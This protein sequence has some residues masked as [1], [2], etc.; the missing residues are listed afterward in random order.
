[1]RPGSPLPLCFVLLTLGVGCSSP[2]PP[3]TPAR[4]RPIVVLETDFGSRED[5]PALLRGVVLAI[6]R[7]ATVVDLTHDVP[8]FDI[9]TGA[10]DLEDAP[11]VFPAGSVFVVVIDPGVGTGRKGIAV[12]LANGRFLVGPDNGVL[13]LAMERWGVKS[14]REI[15]NPAFQRQHQSETFHGRDVFSPA[16][17]FLAIGSPPFA[18]IGPEQ[19]DWVKLPTN[20]V[21]RASGSLHA[22]VAKIDAPYGNVWTNIRPEDLASSGSLPVGTRLRFELGGKSVVVAPL[23]KTF[24]DVKEGEP[25]A[26]WNSRGRLSLALNMGDAAKAY[27]AKR[28]DQVTVSIER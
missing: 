1:M 17:A 16:G 26:Y 8:P 14:V 12:E 11:G 25:L 3:A 23:V 24:G 15:A 18:E 5:A 9:E 19:R 21:E 28:G 7:D 6:A 4:P 27:V 20:K 13:S 10:Q 2:A 22:L